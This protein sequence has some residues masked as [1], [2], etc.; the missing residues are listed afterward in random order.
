MYPDWYFPLTLVHA[1]Q[2]INLVPKCYIA[3]LFI[4]NR[5]KF[6]NKG[7]LMF[8]VF[9]NDLKLCLLG[10]KRK[11]VTRFRTMLSSQDGPITLK[12]LS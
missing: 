6:Q 1:D 5:K 8:P 11:I 12:A 10:D 3:T 7:Q 4:S 9:M 2:R